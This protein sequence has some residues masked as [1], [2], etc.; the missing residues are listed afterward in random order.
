MKYKMTVL[1]E[2]FQIRQIVSIHYFEYMNDFTFAGESHNFWEFLYVDNGSVEITA[3]REQMTLTQGDIIFHKPN[4]FHAVA[5]SGATAPNLVV[6]SFDCGDPAMDFFEERIL[7]VGMAERELLAQILNEA[8]ANFSG[9]LDDPYLEQL[10]R[11]DAPP[12]GSEQM[13]R[14]LLEQFLILLYRKH[15]PQRPVSVPKPDLRL[16][17]RQKDDI[18]GIILAYFEDHISETLTIR[19]VCRDNLVSPAQLKRAFR[20]HGD[21]GILRRFNLM[22]IEHAKQLI[23]NQKYNYTQIADQLGYASIHYFSR[24]FKELAGMT[25]TEYSASL[26]QRTQQPLKRNLPQGLH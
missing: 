25:P 1:Q 20:L 17:S 13:I 14:T 4:E 26:K 19:Q 7:S 2:E 22:K 6:I 5:S 15:L 16:A 21:G 10:V 18:Y 23:R 12:F 11:A 3:N 8:R 9:P 24:Q